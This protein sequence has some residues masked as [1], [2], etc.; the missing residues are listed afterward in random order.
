MPPVIAAYR[1]ASFQRRI[2]LRRTRA[3]RGDEIGLAELLEQ[4]GHFHLRE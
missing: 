2:L 4:V 3:Q 1:L